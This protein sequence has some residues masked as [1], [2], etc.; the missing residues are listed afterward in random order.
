MARAKAKAKGLPYPPKPLKPYSPTLNG[1]FVKSGE[2]Q[3][4]RGFP[5]SRFNPIT[6]TMLPGFEILLDCNNEVLELKKIPPGFLL[7]G[8]ITWI[9]ML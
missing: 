4:Y 6:K 1:K 9:L 5:K 8:L 3:R 2:S 7:I